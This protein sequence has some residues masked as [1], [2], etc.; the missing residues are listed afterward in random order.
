MQNIIIHCGGYDQ[1]NYSTFDITTDW[2]KDLYADRAC[3]DMIIN[4]TEVRGQVILYGGPGAFSQSEINC[5]HWDD[6][7]GDY[8]CELHG[9]KDHYQV[10]I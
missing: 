9:I 3:G 10:G 1:F 2:K 4:A 5:P 8:P 7:I 6:N